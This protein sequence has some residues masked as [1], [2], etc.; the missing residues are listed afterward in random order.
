MK[1]YLARAVG[2]FAVVLF[3]LLASAQFS[4]TPAVTTSTPVPGGTGNF[5]AFTAQDG[6]DPVEPSLD[7]S[8]MVFVGIDA[9]NRSGLYRWDN[10]LLSLVANQNT[11]VPGHSFPFEVLSFGA[12]SGQQ[13]AFR[14]HSP[15]G[16]GVY[17]ANGNQIITI[18]DTSNTFA[19]FGRSAIA[20]GQIAFLGD[21]GPTAAVFR[22]RNGTLSQ[23]ASG[24]QSLGNAHIGRGGYIAFEAH[25]SGSTRGIYMLD[26]ANVLS[27]VADTNMPVP[28]D[29]GNFTYFNV[30]ST[31]VDGPDVAFAGGNSSKA[32]L[33]ARINGT[34]RAIALNGQSAPSGGTFSFD[35]SNE[36]DLSL[37]NQHVAFMDKNGIIYTDY[38]NKLERVIGIGDLLSNKRIDRLEMSPDALSGS[39]LMF[40]AHFTDNSTGIYM[41]RVP[42]P[43]SIALMLPVLLAMRRRRRR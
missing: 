42:E 4:I 3:P 33:F 25:G 17:L 6:T 28:G 38:R 22:Y 41:A 9:N 15:A 14:A 20:D 34:L 10:G 40:T 13:V 36:P 23:V 43:S 8:S 7:G 1:T 39:L 29:P 2:A 24:Y 31:S 37:D 27:T 32:G 16:S 30:V 18:A 11:P 21:F 5:K 12:V 19:G 26:N 35:P